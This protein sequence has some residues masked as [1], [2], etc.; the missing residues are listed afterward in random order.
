MLVIFIKFM[1]RTSLSSFFV[2]IDMSK[3]YLLIPV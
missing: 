1:F 3:L 2:M